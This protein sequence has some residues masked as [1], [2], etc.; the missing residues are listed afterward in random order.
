MNK[1]DEPLGKI[2]LTDCCF[3]FKVDRDQKCKLA[4]DLYDMSIDFL[5]IISVSKL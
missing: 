5:D 3:E 2:T 4:H 1:F